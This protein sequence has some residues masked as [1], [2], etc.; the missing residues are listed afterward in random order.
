ME[1]LGNSSK[2]S[3]LFYFEIRDLDDW[4]Q[5]VFKLVSGPKEAGKF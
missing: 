1:S 2:L 4:I 3:F 5:F